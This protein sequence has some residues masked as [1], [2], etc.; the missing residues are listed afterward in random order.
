MKKHLYYFYWVLRTWPMRWGFPKY[1]IMSI[2]ETIGDVINNK[3]SISRLGDADFL[4]LIEERDVSYQKLNPE[5]VV[6]LREVLRSKS[7]NF[8]VG[9][10]DTISKQSH[11]KLDAKVHWLNFINQ[12]G[13]KLK[14]FIPVDVKF[15]NSNMT[16]IYIET[17]N[18]SRSRELFDKIKT[19]WDKKNIIIIE[20]EFSRL[21]IGNDLFQN[22]NSLKR[23]I[24]PSNNAFDIYEKL[25]NY[26]LKQDKD[27]L[28]LF[29]LGPTATVLCHELSQKGF[30]CVDVGNI[31]LEYMWMLNKATTKMSIKGRFSVETFNTESLEL[32]NEDK[33]N[34]QDSII[35]SFV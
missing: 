24:C 31:D 13:A 35:K 7:D 9:L 14:H 18:L 20:G 1:K 16:R 32:D 26:V 15:G 4:L 11:L 25:K 22:V 27:A 21:G 17:Q 8:I 10:P 6:K 33:K 28:L 19:I 30:W 3:K 5:L 2:E 34:Y 29:A 23:I 12:Y